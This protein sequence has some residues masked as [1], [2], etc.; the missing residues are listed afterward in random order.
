MRQTALMDPV[1]LVVVDWGKKTTLVQQHG[2]SENAKA[3][4]KGFRGK[5]ANGSYED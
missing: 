3:S 4:K 1:S 2:K 5:A